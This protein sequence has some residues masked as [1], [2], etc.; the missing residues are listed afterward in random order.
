VQDNGP[1]IGEIIANDNSAQA[2]KERRR[3]P[4]R[5]VLKSAAIVFQ[6][7]HCTIGCQILSESE[8]GAMLMPVD[9]MSCPA[10]FLLKPRYGGERTCEVVWR[11]GTKIGVRYL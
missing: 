9:V 6:G 11:T 7:G 10:E 1:A 3:R 2:S 4:R 5:R 8:S